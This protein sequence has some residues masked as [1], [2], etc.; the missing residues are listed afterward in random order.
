MTA[1][2][3]VSWYNPVSVALN[4]FLLVIGLVFL[5]SFRPKVQR[6]LVASGILWMTLAVVTAAGPTIW[7][8]MFSRLPAARFVSQF[9]AAVTV[10]PRVCMTIAVLHWLVAQARVR[11]QRRAASSRPT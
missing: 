1:G 3:T 9:Q 6:G 5:I 11:R 10:L 8:I 4:A 7:R 2:I